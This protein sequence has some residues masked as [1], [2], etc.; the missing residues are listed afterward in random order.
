MQAVTTSSK[1][2][3]FVSL[4]TKGIE[5]WQKA[6]EIVVEMIDGGATVEEIASSSEYLTGDVVRRFEQLGRKQIVPRLLVSSF[7]AS[8]NLFKL[9]YSEQKNA[10]ESGVPILIEGGEVLNVAVE[11]LTPLQCRQAFDKDRVRGIAGQRAYIES[12]KTEE[13]LNAI[14]S[15][16]DSLYTIRGRNVIFSKPYRI[17]AKQLAQIL[18]SIE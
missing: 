14:I 16:S 18:A 10:F 4:V 9:S 2:E 6:G 5:C 3:A 13:S 17:S 1:I 15:D 8:K 11:N 7:P 12:V